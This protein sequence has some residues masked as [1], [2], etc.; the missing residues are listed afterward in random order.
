VQKTFGLE[1]LFERTH[2]WNHILE[3]NK[4]QCTTVCTN[5][6]SQRLV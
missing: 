2:F 6:T 1:P 5:L 4:T 3:C